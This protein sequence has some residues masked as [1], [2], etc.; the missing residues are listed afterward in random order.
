[1]Q[2][3]EKIENESVPNNDIIRCVKGFGVDSYKIMIPIENIISYNKKELDPLGVFDRETCWEIKDVEYKQV[4]YYHEE[5]SIRIRLV[6]KHC[7]KKRRRAKWIEIL[8]KAKGIK[9]KYHYGIR[10]ENVHEL[11]RFILESNL[12]N[13]NEKVFMNSLMSDVDIK[14]DVKS[15]HEE[16]EEIFRIIKENL[17][18]PDGYKSKPTKDKQGRYNNLMLSVGEREGTSKKSTYVKWYQKDVE[19]IHNKNK[20][21][22]RR[23]F[24]TD[25]NFEETLRTEYQIRNNKAFKNIFPNKSLTLETLVNLTEEENKKMYKEIL[26]IHLKLEEKPKEKVMEDDNKLLIYKISIKRGR[27]EKN[28]TESHKWS[29]NKMELIDEIKFHTKGKENKDKR[30]REI[31]RV[32]EAYELVKLE[33]EKQEIKEGGILEK[34]KEIMMID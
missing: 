3:Y 1:M 27:S 19:F 16:T 10:K 33:G 14:S 18:S 30:Y 28:I 22:F 11:Y 21:G 6:E 25:K 2:I 26:N 29:L 34:W 7:L 4:K 5:I 15:T 8:P 23:K 13:I 17:R 24:Y 9:E 12:I 32:K 31:K 20:K